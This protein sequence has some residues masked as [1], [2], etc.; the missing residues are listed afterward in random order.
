MVLKKTLTMA[1]FMVRSNLIAH[2]VEWGNLYE[3]HFLGKNLQ[4][5]T[6]ID[7]IFMFMKIF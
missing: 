7:R 3:R 4:E 1:C 5:I 6:Q 2:G